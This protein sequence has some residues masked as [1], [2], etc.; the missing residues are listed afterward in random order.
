M[1]L[2]PPRASSWPSSLSTRGGP[3]GLSTS[4]RPLRPLLLL[5]LLAASWPGPGSCKP[6]VP[7]VSPLRDRVAPP[8]LDAEGEQRRPEEVP[9]PILDPEEARAF[10]SL[11]PE[12]SKRRLAALVE[13]MDADEDG[14][15]SH[16]ELRAWIKFTQRRYAAEEVARH[17]REYDADRDDHVSWD[18]YRNTT[19]GF[20]F[21]EDG[22]DGGDG[23]EGGGYRRM[24]ARDR[25]R[26]SHADADTD[27]RMTREEFSAF[28]HPDE[29]EHMAEL[30]ITETIEDLDKDG[31]GTIDIEEYIGDMFSR[32]PSTGDDAAGLQEEPEWVRT[33][34]A[35]FLAVRDT[36][37]DGRMGRAE[38]R[39]WVLPSDYD[40][41]DIEAQHLVHESDADADGK[42][43]VEEILNKFDL[44]IGSQATN[45][46]EE[47]KRHDEF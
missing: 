9:P 21:E 3:V 36:D 28:L 8:R 5:L 47:L 12:Q 13:R 2:S 37:G 33:E 19:Y 20:Y 46:G 42:L 34:R 39:A 32:E 30:V 38:T 18:E 16:S 15:V 4:T 14:L 26:F 24:L 11:G 31:D 1:N 17:W 35:Q 7:R 27:G 41:A 45:F 10:E 23:E 44:F 29:H 43:S 22:G 25:R 6:A 40:H